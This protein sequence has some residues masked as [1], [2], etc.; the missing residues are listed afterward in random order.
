MEMTRGRTD[1]SS[2]AGKLG[3]STHKSNNDNIL[4]VNNRQSED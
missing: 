3:R 2:F 4:T 1:N